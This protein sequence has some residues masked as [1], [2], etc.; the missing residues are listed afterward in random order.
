VVG[1]YKIEAPPLP[2]KRPSTKD[3]LFIPYV[4]RQQLADAIMALAVLPC[5]TAWLCY[6]AY[7]TVHVFASMLPADEQTVAVLT[8]QLSA[9]AASSFSAAAT[10]ASCSSTADAAAD[11]DAAGSDAA[12]ATTAA[13]P[14]PTSDGASQPVG[15]TE[16][17]EAAAAAAAEVPAAAVAPN[18]AASTAEEAA[19]Q[20]QQQ[21]SAQQK[22][23]QPQ[24]QQQQEQQQ[25]SPQ[26]QQQ[27]QPLYFQVVL[28]PTSSGHAEFVILQSR[29]E[30][31]L[32]RT[33]QA[34]DRVQVRV[35]ALCGC[36]PRDTP[37]ARRHR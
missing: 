33:W 7:V 1:R 26:Q 35:A 34:G 9:P 12:V 14:G 32:Q 24:Q 16:I 15:S 28:P 5:S 25:Q 11:A 37:A 6:N 20:Q 18:A 17:H 27:Q 22:Q 30:A 23:Q 3:I 10:G 19:Q 36:L 8:L 31:A 2:P 13:Q 29:F 4:S 21:Q